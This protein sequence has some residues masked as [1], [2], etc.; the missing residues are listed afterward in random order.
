MSVEC[1][2]RVFRYSKTTKPAERLILLAIANH[3]TSDGSGAYPSIQ[4][5][6]KEAGGVSERYVKEIIR[7]LEEL[8]E[9]IIHTGGGATSN[10]YT[11]NVWPPKS[12]PVKPDSPAN[13]SAPMNYSSPVNQDSPVNYSVRTHEPGF[14]PPM[15]HSSPD[16]S[17]N[18]HKP[19]GGGR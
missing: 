4:T 18:R 1:M 8:G 12:V 17:F 14:T 19:S 2:D 5:L 3:A 11:V 15:N 6:A 9:L 7:N 16:P 10:R 13:D